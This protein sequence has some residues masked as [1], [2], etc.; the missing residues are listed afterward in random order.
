MADVLVVDD[1]PDIRGMLAFLLEDEGHRVRVAG[2]GQ[3]GL[4]AMAER[5]PDCLV[6]DVMMPGLDGFGLLKARRQQGLAPGARV[7]ILTCRAGERDFVRGWELGADEYLTKPFD[8]VDV[9]ARVAALLATRPEDL[10]QR[11]AA[12]L[13]K[14]ELLDRLEAAFTRPTRS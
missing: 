13:Q 9:V 14:A 8:P 1:D 4:A 2:D 10:A 3:A 11:R 12:E 6:V 5:A 7:L